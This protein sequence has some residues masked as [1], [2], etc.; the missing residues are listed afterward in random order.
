M[1]I[2]DAIEQGAM[3][4]DLPP[5]RPG[6]TVR[7]HVKVKEGDKERIQMF[8]GVVIRRRRGGASA[9][10]T[11][12]KISYGVGVERIFPVESPS[13]SKVEIKSRGHV[14]R[15][16]LYFLRELRGKK[17]RLRSKLRDLSA[18]V[19]PEALDEAEAALEAEAAEASEPEAGASEPRP[20]RKPRRA[21][22]S[23]RPSLPRSPAP[24]RAERSV[25]RLEGRFE[26][27]EAPAPVALELAADDVEAHAPG[28]RSLGR[29]PGPGP[30]HQAGAL[31]RVDRLLG[32]AVRACPPRLHLDEGDHPAARGHQ[33]DLDAAGAD[34]ARQHAPA[35]CLQVRGCERF[36][37]G[38][39]RAPVVTS[40]SC[41][42]WTP[43]DAIAGRLQSTARRPPWAPC[44]SSRH[45]SGT[46]R[47]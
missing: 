32:K 20:G 47:T 21:R 41:P 2:M 46:W 1:R 34:V 8:E 36:S 18:L 31:A 24:R 17:A 26:M 40:A 3:R 44:T 30:A 14:R 11:V 12:R 25:S 10:F 33:I 27:T 38:A 42:R 23:R 13:V 29:E 39:E 4:R 9:T 7:V 5:F 15:S 6:D 28:P 43:R 22:P 19:A 16:R 45:P 37:G 35:G